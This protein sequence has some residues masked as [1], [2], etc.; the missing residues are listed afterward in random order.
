MYF[1]RFE[2][3]TFFSL[4]MYIFTCAHSGISKAFEFSFLRY[5]QRRL[6]TSMEQRNHAIHLLWSLRDVFVM[7]NLNPKSDLS[8]KFAT[9][10]YAQ[11]SA[12]NK[13]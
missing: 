10:D 6:L 9:T 7:C 11:P 13:K 1:V 12:S 8:P 4:T 5:P 2:K 3:Y